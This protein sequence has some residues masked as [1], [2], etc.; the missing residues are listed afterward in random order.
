MLSNLIRQYPTALGFKFKI[1]LTWNRTEI[2]LCKL[3][4]LAWAK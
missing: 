1:G 3:C 2:H 4:G